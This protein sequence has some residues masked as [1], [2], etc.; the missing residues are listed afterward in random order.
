MWCHTG[1]LAHPEVMKIAGSAGLS[2]TA[3][4]RH[5]GTHQHMKPA[6]TVQQALA[7]LVQ[8]GP[9]E[10]RAY[11][12]HMA[13]LL[14]SLHLALAAPQLLQ[15]PQLPRMLPT[16]TLQYTSSVSMLI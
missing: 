8:V 2:E 13:G 10:Q 16:G 6:I 12:G 9:H 5:Q 4:G 11:I 15:G 1:F 3:E 14:G 7:A